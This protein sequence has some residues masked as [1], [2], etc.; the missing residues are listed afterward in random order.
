MRSSSPE[1]PGLLLA[2][3]CLRLKDPPRGTQEEPGTG[4]APAADARGGVRAVYVNLVRNKTYTLTVL[5]YAGYTFA[6]GGLAAWMPAFLE[7]VRGMPLAKAT[8]SF[9]AIVV[10]TGFIGTFAGGWLGDYCAKYSRQ[11][12]LWVSAVS[13][14]A[15]VPLAWVALT[16]APPGL[17]LVCMVAAPL[18]LFVSTGPINA[19]IVNLVAPIERASA[20]ALS[21]FTI[22]LLGDVLS[23]PLIGVFSDS[24]LTRLCRENRAGRHSG[25]GAAVVLGG[26]RPVAVRP[27]TAMAAASGARGVDGGEQRVEF[28]TGRDV[29]DVLGQ[30]ALPVRILLMRAGNVD[31]VGH[32]EQVLDLHGG[33]RRTRAREIQ[34]SAGPAPG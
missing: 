20:V 22:H 5:G 2:A 10:V 28:R 19:A 11:A 34:C 32:A 9:G 3:L 27:L 31:R 6:V 26:A 7:R 14:L 24:V 18:L 8:V 21:V 33:Q 17:Y 25:V 12:L 23:P 30:F 29:L 15:A 4:G 13:T 16:A 1:P